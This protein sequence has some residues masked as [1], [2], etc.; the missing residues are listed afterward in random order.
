MKRKKLKCKLNHLFWFYG[1]FMPDRQCFNANEEK[2]AR[3]ATAECTI[4]V[5]VLLAITFQM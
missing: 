4:L 2:G 1:M 5:L 3:N